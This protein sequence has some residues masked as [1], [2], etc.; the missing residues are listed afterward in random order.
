MVVNQHRVVDRQVRAARP[1]AEAVVLVGQQAVEGCADVHAV[2]L[3]VVAGALGQAGRGVDAVVDQQAVLVAVH[4][5]VG[6]AQQGLCPQALQPR[7][8]GVDGG[9]CGHGVDRH[10][11]PDAV[12]T[13][14]RCVV[15]DLTVENEGKR[16]ERRRD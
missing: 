9:G 12:L 8:V 2:D 10:R 6:V 5:V 16:R 3:W 7:V 14:H 4:D 1:H 13:A 11:V 15:G